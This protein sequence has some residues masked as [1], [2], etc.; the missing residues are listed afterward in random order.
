MAT[1]KD[2]RDER[3]RKLDELKTLG[4]DPFPADSSRTHVLKNITDDFDSLNGQEV[5]VVGRIENIRK[6]GS[7]AFVVIRD[8]SGSLQLF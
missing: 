1:L 5:S 6:F 7:I 2:L 4:I 8:Q 3:L